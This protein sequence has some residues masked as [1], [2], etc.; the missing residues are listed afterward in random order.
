MVDKQKNIHD[1]I[2][3]VDV[4]ATCWEF[5]DA[6]KKH[7]EIIE[8][9][10]CVINIETMEIERSVGIY[11]KN[12]ETEISEFCKGIT[13]I[14]QEKIDVEG[15][16]IEEAIGIMRNDFGS[17]R[18][19]MGCWGGFDKW[20][21]DDACKR[22]GIVDYP[23]KNWINIK[24]MFMVAYGRNKCGMKKAMNIMNFEFEGVQHCGK[25][26]AFNT[27]KVFIM[28]MKKIRGEK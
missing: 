15:I 2:N 13:G 6:K 8:I 24:E 21:F 1:R 25:D 12:R 17:H 26:D 22:N 5:N 16:E 20:I 18:R 19:P 9:G 11:V 28:M 27:A 4:E 7:H 10:I 23:F 14:T 3:I